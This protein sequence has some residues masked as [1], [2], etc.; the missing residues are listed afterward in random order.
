MECPRCKV[1]LRQKTY[2]QIEMDT[3][4]ECKGLWLDHPEMDELEDI[5]MDDDPSKGTMIYAVRKSNISCPKCYGPMRIFNYR[6]YDLPIDEC[7]NQHGFWLDHGEEQRVMELMR[8][9]IK[10]IRRSRKAEKDW[11]ELLIKL[12]SKS[13]SDKMKNLFR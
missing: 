13:F 6:A 9:R 7:E 3:C 1:A 2:K 5:V 10:N 4:P 11:S 12:K 8:Q